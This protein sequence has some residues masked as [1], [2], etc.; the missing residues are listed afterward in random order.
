MHPGGTG[1]EYNNTRLPTDINTYAGSASSSSLSRARPLSPA[2]GGAD[3]GSSLVRTGS[4]DVAHADSGK[5]VNVLDAQGRRDEQLLALGK[6][7][8][9]LV[10]E[11]S[12]YTA[13][14]GSGLD[15]AAALAAV[16]AEVSGDHV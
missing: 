15:A 14:L 7:V 1:H 16:S 12:E 11:P 3:W 6:C 8:S 10:M 5:R 4:G 2:E 9:R 13:I